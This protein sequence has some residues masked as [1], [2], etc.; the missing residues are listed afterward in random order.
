MDFIAPP[1]AAS[2]ETD[3]EAQSALRTLLEAHKIV[4]SCD[5]DLFE[6]MRAIVS[7]N[8]ECLESVDEILSGEEDG[9]E[10]PGLSDFMKRL[11]ESRY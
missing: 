5:D 1:M 10:S 8:Q 7:Y 3:Y 4:S 2:P 6:R 9:D 11:K